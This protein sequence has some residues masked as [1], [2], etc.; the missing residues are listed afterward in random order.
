[1]PQIRKY[2]FALFLSIMGCILY[3]HSCVLAGNEHINGVFS[4]TILLL[5]SYHYGYQQSDEV[6]R[7]IFQKLHEAIPYVDIRV[8]YMDTKNFDHPQYIRLFKNYLLE[9]YHRDTFDLII[10]ADDHAFRLMQ[11]LQ[12]DQWTNVPVVFCGLNQYDPHMLE[13]YSN[14]TG[15]VEKTDVEDNIRLIERLHPNADTLYII[16][17]ATLTGKVLRQSEGVA[18]EQLTRMNVQYLD[19]SEYSLD[20][21]L[22]RLK[23]LP[24]ESVVIYQLFLRDKNGQSFMHEEVL[25]M[26]TEHATV[27]VYGFSEVYLGY[28][29]V[30]GKLVSG[31]E[32]GRVS[33]EMAVR[34]LFGESPENIPVY[35]G[36]Q[37]VYKFDD[38]QLKRFHIAA[39]LLPPDC[40][41]IGHPVSFFEKHPYIVIL[42]LIVLLVQ[43][44]LI[45]YLLLSRMWR[46]KIEQALKNEHRML[47]ALMDN[48]P[49]FIYFKDRYS[50]FIQNNKAHLALFGLTDQEEA[51]GKTNFDFFPLDFA[52]ET[53][54]DEKR[55]VKTGNP[56]INKIENISSIKGKPTWVSTTKVPVKDES[57][58]VVTIIG[59]SRD[60]TERMIS[61]EKIKAS[62]EEKEILLKEIHHRVKNN[63]QVISSLLNLQSSTIKDP[64]TVSV[65]KESQ[66]R[67]RSMA[68]IHENLYKSADIS[69]LDLQDYVNTLVNGLKRSYQHQHGRVTFELDI[70]DIPLGIDRAV[71]CG[72]IINELVSNALKHAFTDGHQEP[73]VTIYFTMNDSREVSLII[74]DNGQGMPENFEWEKANSL[75][76]KLVR[77]LAKDQLDGQIQFEHNHGTKIEIRFQLSGSITNSKLN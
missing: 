38:R 3:F 39:R 9:K 17:D 65:L 15:I 16:S 71:P 44:V 74:Q 12:K 59:I 20:A 48:M 29:I 5:N 14:Y 11:R 21:L 26:I 51:L 53:Y 45:V 56:L 40:Q 60:I 2:G 70:D 24:K 58:D 19:G 28:G 31:T 72:L 69:H 68:L 50:R 61:A 13:G 6:T 32:Q 25:P 1:M 67:V 34:I 35:Q 27:P 23:N 52:E 66:D 73:K 54:E 33:A 7:T 43:T 8:E 37:C 75:G 46:V 30:G 47:R 42:A 10:V 36:S 64:D 4:P 55:I 57:G 77:I 63:L 76:L 18:I 49:D 22:A 41:I 62:L